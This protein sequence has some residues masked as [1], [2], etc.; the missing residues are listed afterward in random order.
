MTDNNKDIPEVSKTAV[1]IHSSALPDSTPTVIGYD[2]NKGIDYHALFQTYTRSGF[3]A[4][5]FGLAVEE[6]NK[7]IECRKLPLPED[8]Q[9]FYE[10]DEFI[11]RKHN[12]T[13]FLGYTSNM[14]SCGLRETI[15]FLVEHN[16][17]REVLNNYLQCELHCVFILDRFY[18]YDSR[19]R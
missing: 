3:Q 1:L 17:V 13:V 7:M 11:K 14:V 10:D 16:M 12:C 8:K 9:D 2:W 5:N 15:R 6:I 19:W 18:C 4:T